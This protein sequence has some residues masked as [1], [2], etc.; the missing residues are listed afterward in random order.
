VLNSD[1][2]PNPKALLDLKPQDVV[3]LNLPGGGGYGDPF[4]RDVQKVL[5]DVIEGY[6]SPEE[7]KSRYGVVVQ[8]HGSATDRVRLPQNWMI[9]QEETAKLRGRES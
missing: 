4:Q 1:F 5:W 6:V 2:R 8:Y 7:A 3:H 9:D